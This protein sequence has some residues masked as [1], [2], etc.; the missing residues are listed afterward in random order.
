MTGPHQRARQPRAA[1]RGPRLRPGALEQRVHVHGHAVG[2]Q[3]LHRS[4]ARVPCAG[5][6]GRRGTRRAR[7]L[8]ADEIGQHVDVTSL[9]HRR[10]LDARDDPRRRCS[11]PRRVAS[12]IGPRRVV[13]GDGDDGEPGLDHARHQLGRREPAVR[14]RGVHVEIDH[15]GGRRL[16]T[17]ARGSGPRCRAP[18]GPPGGA[19]LGGFLLLA[20]QRDTR[21]SASRGARAPP[22][23][24][25][26]RSA[27]PRS[28]RSARRSA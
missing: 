27:C 21:E 7:R 12:S 19:S 13:I 28:P 14:R 16:G 9:V 15:D 2:G 20:E 24:T 5:P 23:R 26:G 8:R 4:R 6:A 25:R 10:D 18:R 22:R 11:A 3:A 17:P 1:D